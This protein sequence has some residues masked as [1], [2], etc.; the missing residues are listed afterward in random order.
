[1][2]GIVRNVFRVIQLFYKPCNGVL[3]L[4]YKEKQEYQNKHQLSASRPRSL[5]KCLRSIL[6]S[7]SQ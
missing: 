5:R 6:K 7:T 2:L 4:V 1:M 3:C